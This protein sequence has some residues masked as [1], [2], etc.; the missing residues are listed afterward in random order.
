MASHTS[1]SKSQTVSNGKSVINEQDLR[2][3]VYHNQLTQRRILS[4]FADQRRDIGKECGY[5]E[6]GELTAE[7][8]S[9]LYEREPLA[10]RVVDLMPL[11]CWQVTPLLF[12]TEDLGKTTAFEQAWEDVGKGLRGNSKFQTND[13]N[14]I[15][16]YLERVDRLS[17]VGHYGA[18][19]LGIDDGQDLYKPLLMADPEKS[20]GTG[21]QRKLLYLRALPETECR[22]TQWESDPSNPRYGQ[23]TMY[24]VTTTYPSGASTVVSR[25][26]PVHWTRIVHIADNI[27]RNEIYGVPRM[28]KLYNRLYDL[29]K[30]YGGSA[31]MYWKGAFFGL[32]FETHPQLGGQVDI[33][34]DSMR[35][36]ISAYENTL[37]RYLALP[38]MSVKTLAPQVVDPSP[39][40]E[41]QIEA[42]CIYLGCPKRIFMGSERGELSSAQDMRLWYARVKHRQI[43]RVTPGIIV[44]LVDRLIAAQVLPTPESYDVLWPDVAGLTDQEQAGIAVSR[45]DAIVK[46][47]AG[48]GEALIDPLDYLVRILGFT[49]DE[50]R[51]VLDNRNSNEIE[52]DEEPDPFGPQGA[53][54]GVRV[55][56]MK[57]DDEF[58]RKGGE[59]AFRKTDKEN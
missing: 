11:E 4:A 37:Q 49:Y 16:Q 55:D 8:Y 21:N 31:E 36:Q 1:K 28:Q 48:Q 46:Y 12:E 7:K 3:L 30:L 14:P 40:I 22:I 51:M 41:R 45:T 47:I 53:P 10:A 25:T 2:E 27:D 26:Q 9:E 52:V 33:D 35:A 43:T 24:D 29:H 57:F 17:G 44:P 18:L 6:T 50:A 38:G 19:L 56:K 13:G 15:W 39:Q 58:N 32:A 20:V 54:A 42:I 34:A 59:S 5:P 23:P